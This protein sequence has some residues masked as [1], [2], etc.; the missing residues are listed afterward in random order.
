MHILGKRG[1][2]MDGTE[3]LWSDLGSL[4][5]MGVAQRTGVR[6]QDGVYFVPFLNRELRVSPASRSIEAPGLNS[7]KSF[8]QSNHLILAILSF[9][10][11][12]EIRPAEGTWINEKG[13]PG[14]SLFFQGPH[15]MPVKPIIDKFGKDAAAFI[16]RGV[17]LGGSQSE[18]GDGSIKFTALP[19]LKMCFV[20]W[21]E[22]DEFPPECTVMFDKSFKSMFALDIV[23]GLTSAIVDVIASN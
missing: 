8:L 2:R 21:V 22:D 4:D 18:F 19:G 20:L 14:G 17:F 9:L 11:T 1:V 23:L 5:G 16:D 15:K 7:E 10:V 12:G 13:L 6:F 3:K